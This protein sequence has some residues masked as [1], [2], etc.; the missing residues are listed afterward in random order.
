MITIKAPLRISYIGGGSDF[1]DYILKY[2]SF[3]LG[4]T[5][6]KYVYTSLNPLEP[7]AEQK[8][9]LTYRKVENAN[10]HDGISHPIVREVL[11]YFKCNSPLNISTLADLPGNSGLGSSSAFTVSFIAGISDFLGLAMSREEIAKLS[12]HIEREI[13]LEAG[14]IQDQ[15]H[16]SIGGLRTYNFFKTNFEFSQIHL[17]P[18]MREYISD[19][20]WLI[21]IGSA[22]DSSQVIKFASNNMKTKDKLNTLRT[23][24]STSA[25]IFH[26][27]LV[28]CTENE[29]AYE[30]IFQAVEKSWDLKRKFEGVSSGAI[31]S[32][33][34]LVISAGADAAKICGAGGSGFL[35][36]LG[37]SNFREKLGATIEKMSIINARIIDDGFKRYSI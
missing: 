11:K 3:V 26:D 24:L 15:Y 7:W 5:I 12:V 20:Q 37:D 13:L 2:P 17:T 21:P 29:E 18:E 35:L 31:E 4:T 32:L 30:V 22:R 27:R 6:N 1:A 16:S 19:R 33:I 8:F 25:K 10:D 23:E 9:R 28:K 34:D 36:V 14:G